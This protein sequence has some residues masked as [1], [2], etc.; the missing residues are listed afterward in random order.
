MSLKELFAEAGRYVTDLVGNPEVL[1]SAAFVALVLVLRWI[2]VS[3]IRR[4]TR[5]AN[6]LRRRWM[7]Q[8][9][10]ATFFV[11]AGGLILI[12]GAEIRT[13][14]L[15]AVAIAAALAISLKELL[16]CASGSFLKL[17]AGSF[18]VGDRIE[19]AGH[20]GDVFDQTLLTTTLLEIGPGTTTH[21]H[22][23]RTLVLPNSLLLTNPVVNET[24]TGAFVLHT[25]HVPMKLDDDWRG[26][27]R[28]L[29]EA[30][31]KESEAYQVEARRYFDRLGQE[32][33][34]SSLASDPRVTIRV[35]EPGRIDLTVRVPAPA[36]R[37][38]RIEQAILRHAVPGAT[39]PP[40][41]DP[42]E[43]GR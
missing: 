3:G 38:G 34:I 16:M 37:R 17:V 7:V 2:L 14:A 43:E 12:W 36:I 18:T 25:F 41:E 30:S 10:N 5:L 6:D 26:M 8:A 32:Q 13:A 23:G 27:E 22:T 15:S 21:Q 19:L 40:K 9:R 33:G 31:R 24:A 39:A 1:T 4:S 11:L 29:L 28:R 20:R 42:G 35:P